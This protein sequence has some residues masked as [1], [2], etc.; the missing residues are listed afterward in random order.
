MTDEKWTIEYLKMNPISCDDFFEMQKQK[1]TFHQEDLTAE[2]LKKL[3]IEDNLIDGMIADLFGLT[4]SQVKY[5]RKK[6]GLE[7]K[8]LIKALYNFDNLKQE[9]KSKLPSLRDLD[10]ETMIEGLKLF[11]KSKGW[12]DDVIDKYLNDYQSIQDQSI[13]IVY[14][15]LR[16]NKEYI[17]KNNN[18]KN[19]NQLEASRNKIASGKIGENIVK[20]YEINKLKK[21]GKENLI[22]DVDIISQID[23]QITHDGEGYDVLSFNEKGEK[24]YIE[25]K[26]SKTLSF[27]H[28]N[29]M[30]SQKEVEFMN[31]KLKN[32]DI[33]HCYIY[34]VT[35]I[36][37][38]KMTGKIRIIDHNEFKKYKL[39]PTNFQINEYYE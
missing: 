20:K 24:I 12:N 28:V 36:N 15:K 38:E 3:A 1:I 34:Y 23:D 11:A 18:G 10:V 8:F 27:N 32:I 33:N 26:T 2:L 25:V 16:S 21:M 19:I 5:R 30:I 6:I 31:G 39:N 13:Q 14:G 9:A 29:F 35:D 7:N 37:E 4:K 22:G 17:K